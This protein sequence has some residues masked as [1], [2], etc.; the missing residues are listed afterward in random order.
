MLKQLKKEVED[1]LQTYPETRDSDIALTI[2]VWKIYYS[3]EDTIELDALYVLPREDNIKRIRAK[4][5]EKGLY[6]S[7]NPEVRKKRHQLE[8]K[9]RNELGYNPE[10]RTVD[11]GH[12]EETPNGMKF[13][14]E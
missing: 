2:M 1:I 10:M 14:I 4:F 3:V 13:I 12:W 6:L 11:S 7:D 8:E 9:W 5:N